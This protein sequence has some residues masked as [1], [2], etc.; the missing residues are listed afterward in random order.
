MRWGGVCN[1]QTVKLMSGVGI[2]SAA[3]S[4]NI[5]T[6]KF[7]S[8]VFYFNGFFSSVF[9]HFDCRK[10]ATADARLVLVEEGKETG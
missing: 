1:G 7:K 10:I 4:G 5:S 6:F 8:Y 3:C 2:R 9:L